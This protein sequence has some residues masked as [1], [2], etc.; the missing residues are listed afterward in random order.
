MAL[1]RRTF[2]G[3]AA[4]APL[5]YT[6]PAPA[7]PAR[8]ARKDCFFGL[9][10]DLHPNPS[11][12][13][14]GRDLND[15]MVER[16]LDQVKPDFVQYDCKGHVGYL[17]YP[18]KVGIS[19]PHIVQDSL[20]I[21]RRGTA[22]HGVSLY[23]HFSGVWDSL[24]IKQ[25]PEWASVHADGTPDPNA[26][27]TYGPY[28]DKLMI[29]EL[30]EA[31][32]NYDLDGAWIDG[33]CWALRTDYSPAA[34]RAFTEATGIKTL[35][36]GPGDAGWQEFLGIQRQQ[37]RKY[38]KHYLDE[39]HKF[40]PRFQAASNWMYTT[41]VPE[42]PELPVDYLSGDYLGN[43]SIST[44][45]LDARYLS[46]VGRSWDLMAWGFQRAEKGFN[47]KS[48]VQL[49]QEAAVVLAQ[50]GGFQI[51]YTPTRAGW[52]DQRN[53]AVMAKVAR[54]CRERQ[55][56]SHQSQSVPQ[57]AVLFSKNSLYTTSN[58]LFGGWGRATDPARGMID[59]LLEDHYPVDVMPDWKVAE[60]AAQY[61]LL[62]VPDWPNIGLAVKQDLLKYARAGG[63][64]LIAGAENASLFTT[65]LQVTLAGRAGEQT[66]FLPGEEVFG[67]ATGSWQDVEPA[68]ARMLGQ[69]Y[70][71]FDS[72]RDAKCAATVN[73][74]GAGTVA[75]IYGPIGKVFASS[76]AAAIREFTR[77]VVQQVFTP[78]VKLEAP[79][80]VEL[81]L[82]RKGGKLLV[83]LINC[84]AMQVAGDYAVPDF[85]P[86]V[87]PIEMSVKLASQ[88]A[89]VTLEPGGQELSGSWSSG[90]WTGRVDRL[91]VHRI[92]SFDG[93]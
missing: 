11:D 91:D 21:W 48:S 67:N 54:F 62:V 26:T 79:P 19:A 47:H 36:A 93:A 18:S 88:P 71:T 22:K 28:V 44:A 56:L 2:L 6:L 76:H 87:G 1:T 61:P 14:L 74:L 85:I 81:A 57:I 17:G 8:P 38:L 58:K 32:Q 5:A 31:I 75:A 49:Q 89:R 50:G 30:K 29:P 73:P 68:G 86:P 63:H 45:R 78:I 7:Q 10:F 25:H 66:A 9:H 92:V 51:Y 42:R 69:R 24:A 4:A 12:P 52:I 70:A 34:A 59:L 83:H 60:S 84:T 82:R 80:T 65:E 64:L 35:P 16:L 27:S 20:A 33:E 37:F 3:S 53:V 40:R 46:A 15:A 13:A 39:L 23:I 41:L 72:N 55:A 90:A 43:A 77:K